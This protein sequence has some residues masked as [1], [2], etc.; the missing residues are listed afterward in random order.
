MP[1]VNMQISFFFQPHAVILHCEEFNR[2]LVH[3]LNHGVSQLIFTA[4]LQ[5]Q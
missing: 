4:A 3:S 5:S 1:I 2:L